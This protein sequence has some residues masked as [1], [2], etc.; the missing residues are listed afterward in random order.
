MMK[1]QEFK[2]VHALDTP[3][4]PWIKQNDVF[5]GNL[6]RMT[7]E[8][9]LRTYFVNFGE[10]IDVRLMIDK[11]TGQSRR[12]AFISF[13]KMESV[14][15][16]LR[17]RNQTLDG[18]TIDVKK[19]FKTSRECPRLPVK[20]LDLGPIFNVPPPTPVETKFAMV[21]VPQ[22]PPPSL[23]FQLPRHDHFEFE[24]SVVDNTSSFVRMKL[25]F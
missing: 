14:T 25:N 18:M 23:G 2:N 24:G 13:D 22:H 4:H 5:V 17:L 6:S 12:F 8:G 1:N 10:V 21:E 20:T 15:K 11:R 19:C 3:S 16:V 9:T 7:T